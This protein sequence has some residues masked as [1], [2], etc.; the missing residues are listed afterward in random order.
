[1]NF[2]LGNRIDVLD[3]VNHR[4]IE[5]NVIEISPD[6]QKIKVHYKSYAC[7][8]DEFLDIQ[9]DSNRILEVGS[10]SNA[11]GWAKYSNRH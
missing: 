10:I 5:A 3:L 9:R 11:E 6:Q 7:N 8:R 2:K 1:M 4:W